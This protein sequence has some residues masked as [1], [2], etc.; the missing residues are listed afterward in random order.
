MSE[1]IG[2]NVPR[3]DA[4]SKVTGEAIFT[5]DLK[6]SGLL[7][8]KVLR[9]PYPHALIRRINTDRAASLPG[10]VSVL[11]STDLEDIDP[12]YGHSIKDRPLLA[13]DRVRFVGEPLAAVAA[14]DELTAEQALSLI[15]VEYE[16]LPAATTLEEALSDDA[17][18]LHETDTLRPGLFHGL[19]ELNPEGNIC[20]QHS[21]HR[22]DLAEAFKQAEIIVEQEYTFPAVYQY[23]MEP[24][25]VI[26]AWE[27]KSVTVWA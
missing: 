17:P 5:G 11:T 27:G 25:T 19:G 3:V 10:V 4:R 12:Y 6:L 23:A 7:H 21:I 14:E 16:D 15:E 20:Y 1:G 8:G 26:A 2:H 13:I 18:R 22:G 9:S 24:H